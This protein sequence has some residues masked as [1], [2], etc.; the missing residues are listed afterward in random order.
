MLILALQP[1]FRLPTFPQF[2][3]PPVSRGALFFLLFIA[4][5]GGRMFGK[6]EPTIVLLFIDRPKEE[7]GGGSCVASVSRQV[8][9]IIE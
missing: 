4:Q 5:W 7:G 2:T 6:K 8:A 3:H 9:V 1:Q